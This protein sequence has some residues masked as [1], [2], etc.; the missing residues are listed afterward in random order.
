MSYIENF[1]Q[2]K[3]ALESMS[4]EE[5]KLPNQPIDDY[6]AAIEALS[7][8]A[9]ED[10]GA[11]VSVGLNGQ[12]IDDLPSLSGALRYC[13]AEWMSVY[14]AREDA[15]IEWQEKSPGAYELR[16]ELLH[17]FTFA[18]R[19]HDDVL[20]KVRRIREGS[21][22]ADMIQDLIELAVLGEKNPEPL[23]AISFDMAKFDGARTLSQ[24]MSGLLAAVNGSAEEG[25]QAKVL[26]DKAF[27]LLDEKAGSI[28]EFGKY[29]FWKDEKKQQRYFVE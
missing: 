7:V 25:N 4:L 18:Y 8:A 24:Q 23:A 21:S 13:Q 1:E 15:R 3:T 16:D 14:R 28:R 9:N 6:V 26:R 29:V 10:R 22:H 17:H 5:V 11:L 20:N 19:A 12:L 27:T 2:W